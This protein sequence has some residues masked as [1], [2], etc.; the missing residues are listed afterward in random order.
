MKIINEFWYTVCDY[1]GELNIC[2]IFE[3]E[4]LKT[5]VETFMKIE[6]VKIPLGK[7]KSQVYNCVNIRSG[8]L[9]YFHDDKKLFRCKNAIINLRPEFGEKGYGH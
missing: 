3:I 1:F 8:K 7:K 2:E 4:D 9:H 6:T 5:S